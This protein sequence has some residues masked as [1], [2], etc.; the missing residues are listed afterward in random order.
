MLKSTENTGFAPSSGRT[1]GHERRTVAVAQAVTTFG[2]ALCTFVAV[3]IVSI[4]IARANIAATRIIDNEGSVFA[5]ALV[6][7]LLF[8]IMGGLTV[9]TLPHRRRPQR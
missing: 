4:E 9:L 2:L 3:F 6:L 1:L 7:G 5:L 8:V